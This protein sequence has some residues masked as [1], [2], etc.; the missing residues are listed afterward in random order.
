M[1]YFAHILPPTPNSSDPCRISTHPT[2]WPLPL[3]P[4]RKKISKNKKQKLK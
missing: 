2:P 4:K 1:V 3:S